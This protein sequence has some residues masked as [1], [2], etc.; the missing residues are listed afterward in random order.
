MFQCELQLQLEESRFWTDSVTVL[1][2][3]ENDA[4][5][6]KTFVANR[7]TL[8]KEATRPSQWKYVST[9]DNPADQASR[10]ISAES[11][12]QSQ[13]WIQGPE[14]LLR[15]EDEWPECPDQS[16]RL[17][18]EDAEVKRS[19]QVSLIQADEKVNTMTQFVHHFSSWYKLKKATAWLMRLK[20]I[21]LSIRQKRKELQEAIQKCENNSSKAESLLQQ[22]MLKYKQSFEKQ[23]LTTED[24]AKAETE[25]ICLCQKGKYAEEL[26]ALLDG[27][28]HVRKDSHIFKLDPYLKDG[29]LRVGGR[30]SR[31]AMPLDARH[32][33]I[34]HKDDW[35]AKLILRHI[36]EETGHS[37]RNYILARLRQ[38]FWIPKACSAIQRMI[39]EFS[40]CRR[41][42][43]VFCMCYTLK[44]FIRQ[45]NKK[46]Q[47]C[48]KI[49]Y[50]Q[51]SHP[52]QTPAWISSAHL[53]SVEVAAG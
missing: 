48:Q 44:S 20:E 39:S 37:G 36:H 10:G 19:A 41:L 6:Y 52:S 21:L 22:K 5:R 29:V 18:E 7:V 12:L 23:V 25:L 45:V 53:K 11:L 38:K 33:A 50:R 35:I 9:S 13:N 14:F 31:S 34:L 40:T 46:W 51:I 49:G 1:K 28:G 17:E 15:P 27:K 32:P 30:L 2:Y 47:I 8:I 16:I 43:V 24:L 4:A 42:H 3:I 26:K